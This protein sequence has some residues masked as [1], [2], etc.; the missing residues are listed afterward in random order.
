MPVNSIH[1]SFST[2][3]LRTAAT[4]WKDNCRENIIS[5]QIYKQ[6][7]AQM[8]FV[9]I[10]GDFHLHLWIMQSHHS[11][12]VL[13]GSEISQEHKG[14]PLVSKK[15][16]WK[17]KLW[18]FVCFCLQHSYSLTIWCPYRLPLI[19]RHSE[20]VRPGQSFGLYS[21]KAFWGPRVQTEGQ[22]TWL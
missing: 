16:H 2:H 17:K 3:A 4:R 20:D 11:H 14:A 7:S 21:A 5:N 13:G 22:G 8:L 10:R 6:I 19:S 12:W 15:Q 18:T 1:V 9:G